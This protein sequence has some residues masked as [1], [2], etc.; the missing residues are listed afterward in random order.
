VVTIKP[1][2]SGAQVLTSG[3]GGA[4]DPAWSPDGRLIAYAGRQTGRYQIYVMTANGQP[5][6]RLTNL[7]GEQTDPAWSPRGVSRPL[8]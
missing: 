2:G 5:I 1:D 8:D 7:P 4:E 3:Y 6:K